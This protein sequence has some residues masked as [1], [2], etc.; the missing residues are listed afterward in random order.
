[1]R[2]GPWTDIYACAA[3]MYS[4]F[5]ANIRDGRL[6]PPSEPTD[7]ISRGDVLSPIQEVSKAKLS[8]HVAQAIMKGLAIHS[9]QR[10]QSITKFR[11][12][13]T[14]PFAPAPGHISNFEKTSFRP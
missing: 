12:L 5:R 2:Q 6:E 9:E 3:T 4:C 7:R 8:P 13:L 1:M 10:P 14:T 11:K